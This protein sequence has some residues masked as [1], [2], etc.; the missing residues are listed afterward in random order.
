MS[1]GLKSLKDVFKNEP[2]L[3]NV[4]RI[5]KSSDVVVDF[6]K[7]FPDLKKIAVPHKVDKMYLKLKVSNSVWRS[8]LKF[9]EREIVEKINKFYNEERI[10]GIKFTN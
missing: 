3:I 7:V 8:E 2:Q 10:K 6:Y 4:R 1:D 9:K 5:V